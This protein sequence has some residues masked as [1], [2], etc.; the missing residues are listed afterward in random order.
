VGQR[1]PPVDRT[2]KGGRAHKQNA[3]CEEI[4]GRSP[5]LERGAVLCVSLDRQW[6]TY[7]RILKYP[8]IAFYD[9]RVAAPEDLLTI[10]K[11]PVLFVL[12]VGG[13]AHKDHWPVIGHVPLETAPVPIPDQFM[14]AIGSGAC[15]IVDE[16]FNS[17]A[18][19]PQ[20]CV[21]L[22]RVAVWDP[23]HVEE[24]IRDHYAGRPNAH[25]AY[26]KVAL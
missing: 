19:Q 1:G 25:L 11:R 13:R 8:K 26:M 22:E 5:K 16:F 12:A 4:E 14:Q 15:R 7:A 23:K 10:A 2:S 21:A 20:E 24:R 6:H 3:N 17:R 9:C 18:A